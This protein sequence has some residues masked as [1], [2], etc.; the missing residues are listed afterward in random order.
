MKA[1]C[2]GACCGNIFQLLSSIFEQTTT[3]EKEKAHTKESQTW[4]TTYSQI[5]SF[6]F[7]E[8]PEL[9]GDDATN[10]PSSSGDDYTEGNGIIESMLFRQHRPVWEHDTD[11]YPNDGFSVERIQLDEQRTATLY[12]IVHTVQ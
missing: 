5:G 11:D 2:R 9:I 3:E 8:V 12:L 10:S 6:L 1:G 4:S 7:Q